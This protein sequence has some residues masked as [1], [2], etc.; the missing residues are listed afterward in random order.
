MNKAGELARALP[1]FSP[2]KD[3]KAMGSGACSASNSPF[4]LCQ[5]C[6][7]SHFVD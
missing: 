7:Q 4:I 6:F 3:A 1:V 5:E 2:S